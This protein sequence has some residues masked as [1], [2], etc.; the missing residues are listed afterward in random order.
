MRELKL[1]SGGTCEGCGEKPAEQAHHRQFKSRGGKGTL[2]NSLHL[3]GS[4]N[5]TAC[6]GRAHSGYLGETVGWA[7]R[8][9]YS[10]LD[11]PYFRLFDSTWWRLDDEG[12]KVQLNPHDAIE[13]LVLIGAIK[14]GMGN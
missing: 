7:I 8:S 9:G 1:R 11:V 3:C 10:P 12:G 5:H 14:Q 13:Y 4:G 2:S 6:H